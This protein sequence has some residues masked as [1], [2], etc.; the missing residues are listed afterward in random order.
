M[1][2]DSHDA[3]MGRMVW[4]SDGWPI[5]S[6]AP[7]DYT[8]AWNSIYQ[9]VDE[10]RLNPAYKTLWQEYVVI[11]TDIL[12]GEKEVSIMYVPTPPPNVQ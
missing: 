11:P 6:I 1:H 5:G 4:M 3:E 2:Y 10:T 9:A 12:I 7:W 8:E